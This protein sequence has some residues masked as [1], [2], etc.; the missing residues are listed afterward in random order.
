M[1][2]WELLDPENRMPKRKK[3]E[4]SPGYDFGSLEADFS[5]EKYQQINLSVSEN[6]TTSETT[7]K[8]SSHTRKARNKKFKTNTQ[9]ELADQHLDSK[10]ES[11]ETRTASS[12]QVTSEAS[13][14]DD[15]LYATQGSLVKL[16]G[17]QQVMKLLK[18]RT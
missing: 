14:E 16:I 10:K 3:S 13:G 6:V 12:S 1:S 4:R 5:R 18:K 9:S 8:K 11:E 7:R 17:T 2:D 15:F